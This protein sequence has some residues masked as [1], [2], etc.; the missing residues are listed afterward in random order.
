MKR[1]TNVKPR[2]A[3]RSYESPL[4]DERAEDTR[5]R[6]LDGLVRTMSRGVAE[7]S[8]PAV[9]AEAGVSV[10]TVYRHFRTKSELVAALAPYLGDKSRLMEVPS[11][12]PGDLGAMVRE[13]YARHA[14][15]APEMRAAMASD[16]GGE[17]RRQNMPRRIA[18][19]RKALQEHVPGI[20]RDDLEHLT[21]VALILMA[22]PTI[23]AFNDYL[24]LEPAAAADDVAWALEQMARSARRKRQ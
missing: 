1:I 3:S 4:R 7:L 8:I 6:I 12:A 9:A 24:D 10:P 14:A 21:H 20:A 13:L 17:V 2:K 15:L 16:L 5:R 11:T 22:T 19:I 18:M 23:R